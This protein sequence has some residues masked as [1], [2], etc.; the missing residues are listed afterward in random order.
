MYPVGKV[1][2]VIM[3]SVRDS[4]RGLVDF[5]DLEPIEQREDTMGLVEVIMYCYS[6]LADTHFVPPKLNT[7]QC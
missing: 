7:D 2:L 3:H 5:L 1:I 6:V 4:P